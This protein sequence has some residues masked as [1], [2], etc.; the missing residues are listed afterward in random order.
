MNATTATDTS[1]EALRDAMIMRIT[2]LGYVLSGPVEAALRAVERYAF[3]PDAAL[4]EAYA[5]GIVVTK[6]GPGNEVLSCLSEPGIVALQLGQLQVRPG[7]RVLESRHRRGGA[8]R[9]RARAAGWR[10]L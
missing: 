2:G 9:R 8:R 4:T 7:H 10:S 6:R 5:S 1:P 3:V